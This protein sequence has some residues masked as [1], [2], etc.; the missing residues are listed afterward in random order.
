M[1][2]KNATDN[3]PILSNVGQ[4]G[5]FRIRNSAKAFNILSSG[6]YANKIRAI[7]RE[8]SC[9]AV[10]SHV[11]AGRASTP[12]DVHLPNSLEPWFAV[13]DYGVGLDEQQVRNIFTTYFESTKTATDELIGGLGLGSKSAFS[14]TDNFTIVAIKHGIKRVFTAFINEQG[15]PSIAPM[16]E[17]ETTDPN[18]VEIR[19]AVEN[20][21]D[22]RKFYEEARFVYKHFALRPVV[23]GGIGEFKFIEPEYA[24]RD[25]V[26]GVHASASGQG[27][28]V[29]IMGHIEYPLQVPGNADL[30]G[31]EHLLNCGLTI[32]FGIGE[33]DIQASREG[34]SYIPETIAAIKD[35]LEAV[36]A[37]LATKIAEEVGTITNEWE[38]AYALHRKMQSNLWSAAAAKYVTDNDFDLLTQGRWAGFKIKTFYADPDVLAKKYNI[39]V[40]AFRVSSSYSGVSTT[41]VNHQPVYNTETHNYEDRWNIPL[42]ET[43][44]FVEND[45]TVGA[46]TRARFHWRNSPN[47][48]RREGVVFVLDKADRKLDMNLAA[49]YESLRN[50]PAAQKCKASSLK[51][52]ERVAGIGKDVSLLKLEKRDNKGYLRSDDMVWRDAGKLESFNDT[53]TYY[54][55]PMSGFSPGGI[56]A[57]SGY[58]MK[59]FVKALKDSGVLTETVYG[60]R[61][62]D[63]KEVSKKSNW[64][65]LDD[66]VKNK[67]AQQGSVDVKGLIKQS[68]DFDSYFKFPIAHEIL[69]ANSPYL[70]L[71]NEFAGVKAVD[72]NA[73]RGFEALC[74]IYNVSAGNINVTDEVAKYQKKM[75]EV[76]ARYPLISEL[77]HY[78]R[79]HAAVSEY[80]NA[81]DMLKK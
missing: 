43:T 12:F 15:V 5:E 57:E 8:Y 17:E 16:G 10:D 60:V 26:P 23:S 32:E 37:V 19:F 46:A 20:S 25:I 11:E 58:D 50:P 30:G 78:F 69:D 52:K 38:K 65:H 47:A 27:Q 35:K 9:N 18:G 41:V 31:L 81:I 1:I 29:A 33:L 45:T 54:Y 49:F 74:T 4:V 64:A 55:L 62:A 3:Q 67:L 77:S 73:R 61:K 36:N 42:A 72:K 66:F 68:I 71:L 75:N 79:N 40:S 44:Q 14:Y 28:C 6:L 51:Q 21:Y 48:G 13:R 53:Q 76:V 59:T 7:I 63:I 70:T 80:I 56:A 2:I 34:L 22:F 24:D 39:K